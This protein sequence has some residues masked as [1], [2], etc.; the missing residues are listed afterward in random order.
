[1]AATTEN[2]NEVKHGISFRMPDALAVAVAERAER[3]QLRPSRWALKLVCDTLGFELPKASRN[4]APKYATQEER[5]A[6]RKAS[7]TK[8]NEKIKQSLAL[9]EAFERFQKGE[10]TM[11]DVNT[12]ATGGT[13]PEREPVAA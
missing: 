4:R 8:R 3:E 6:A 9:M 1:M 2:S 10:I 5:D 7:I 13:L 11:E 12:V